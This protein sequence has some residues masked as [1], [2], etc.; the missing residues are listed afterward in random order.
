MK[1]IAPF[2][3]RK[4]QLQLD[5]WGRRPS[6][7]V[8]DVINPIVEW[9]DKVAPTSKEQYPTPWHTERQMIRMINQI[10]LAKCLQD[11][12]ADLFKGM[13][14]DELEECARSF[15]FEK[16]I[17]RDGLNKQLE[18]HAEATRRKA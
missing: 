8:E 3:V 16:C 11:E 18:A 13:S 15:S 12:F 5:A 10:W 6:K 2:M 7:E 4:R 17:Q 14:K 9:I 1:T